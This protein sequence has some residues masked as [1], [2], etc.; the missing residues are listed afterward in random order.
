MENNRKKIVILGSGKSILDLNDREIGIINNC[1]YIIAMNKY[2]AFY[3]ESKILPNCI[4]FHDIY[5]YNVFN[6][7]VK[8]CLTNKLEGLAFFLHPYLGMLLYN[9]EKQYCWHVLKDIYYRILALCKIVLKMN[10]DCD[11][12]RFILSRPFLYFQI[13]SSYKV[14]SVDITDWIKAGKWADSFNERLFH[15]RGSLT[16]CLNVASILSNDSDI[17]LVGND[18]YGSEYFY[19]EALNK[20]G[21]K[22]QDDTFA[23]VK[24][25]GVHFSFIKVQ[26]VSMEEKF[27]FIIDELEKRGCKLY[28][29]NPESL[30]V[31]KAGVKYKKI[32]DE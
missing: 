5:G 18:F 24:K 10:R 19:E 20:L 12:H 8:K 11:L 6:Y 27:P 32:D 15:F 29:V 13:P 21:I 2:M 7:I 26:G 23:T 9:G 30:L 14:Q 4:Y 28:C 31:K 17:Y 1:N 16:T 25:S 22:W 3:D